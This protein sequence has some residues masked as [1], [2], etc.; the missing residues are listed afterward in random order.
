MTMT[1]SKKKCDELSIIKINSDY[2]IIRNSD[3][4][5][6]DNSNKRFISD[7]IRVPDSF[8]KELQL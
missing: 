5:D 7:D 3:H 1:K 4:D 6:N 2:F 8:N